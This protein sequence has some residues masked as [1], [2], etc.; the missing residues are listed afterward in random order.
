MKFKHKVLRKLLVI[1][2]FALV[3]I[4]I[5]FTGNKFQSVQAVGYA[6]DLEVCAGQ[7]ARKDYLL[8][9]IYF[10]SSRCDGARIDERY[11]EIGREPP[12]NVW[13]YESYEEMAIDD[14]M[15]ICAGQSLPSGWSKTDSYFD[16]AKCNGA[17]IDDSLRNSDREPPSNVWTIRKVR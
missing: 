7:G 3:L 10:D 8:T 15:I 9:D 1:S 14:E 6:G 5:G 11:S 4:G 12:G 16:S 13:L 2:I 17:Y